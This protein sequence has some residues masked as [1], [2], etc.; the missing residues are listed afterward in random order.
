MGTLSHAQLAQNDPI[1]TE[2][3]QRIAPKGLI[4]DI[5]APPYYKLG[6]EQG[7]ILVWDETNLTVPDDAV[8]A[9]G[10]LA[11]TDRDPEPSYRSYTTLTYSRKALITQRELDIWGAASGDPEQLR[12]A[13]TRKVANKMALL[14]EKA[15]ADKMNSTSNYESGYSTTLTTTWDDDNGDPIGTIQAAINAIEDGGVFPNSAICDI[16]VWRSLERH[17]ALLEFMKYTKGGMITTDDFVKI[18]GLNLIIGRGRYKSGSTKYAVWGDSLIVAAI[19]PPADPFAEDSEPNAI[20]T[21]YSS[22]P[23]VKVYDAEDRDHKGAQY[24]EMES[25]YSHEWT[26]VDNVTDGDSIAAYLI[27]NAI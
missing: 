11:S 1:C 16:K 7:K 19:N 21:V 26:C 12:M 2:L 15:L 10:G 22:L 9:I 6:A 23:S 4:A 5:V 27:D 18:F 20:R 25:A 17:A 24:V 3:A 8:R 13:K 14:R